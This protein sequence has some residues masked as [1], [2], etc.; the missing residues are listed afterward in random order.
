MATGILAKW[1]SEVAERGFT[2]VPNY[3][4]LLNQFLDPEV[5]L[6]SVELMVL[7]QLVGT[8]WDSDDLPF[9]SMKTLA[10]RSG[11]SERQVQ[12]T[13]KHLEDLGVIERVKR[14]RGLMTSNAYNMMPLVKLLTHIAMKYPNDRPRRILSKGTSRR[15]RGALPRMTDEEISDV[16]LSGRRRTRVRPRPGNKSDD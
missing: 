8:W 7:I 15:D 14:G 11:V 2:Q 6:T 1:G 13:I 5:R 16:T 10:L 3:L 12:R 4:L 9:P